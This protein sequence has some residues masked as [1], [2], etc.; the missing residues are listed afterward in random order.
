MQP[1]RVE[2]PQADLDDLRRRP[3]AVRRP[4]GLPE[5]VEDLQAFGRQ[6]KKP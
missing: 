4:V 5:D 1:F 2:I 3:A 6:V